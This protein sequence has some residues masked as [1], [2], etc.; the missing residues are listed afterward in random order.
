MKL[1]YNLNLQQTQKLVMTPELKQSIEILQYN[2]MELNE[3]INDALLT[4]PIL[5]KTDTS[6]VEEPKKDDL[7]SKMD[8]IDWTQ[9]SDDIQI[10]SRTRKYQEA[11]EQVNYDNF[12][13]S[14][15]TLHEHLLSQLQYTLIEEKYFR[16][17]TYI[18]QCIDPSGY[19]HMEDQYVMDHFKIDE[20]TLEEIILTVQTFDPVGVGARDLSEC[21]LIQAV[22]KHIE[23]KLVYKIITDYLE[24]VG[25]NKLNKI[26]KDLDV[27]IEEVKEAIKTIRCFEP[28][29]GRAF[30]SL[31]DI[32]YIKPDVTLR[33]I[34]GEF[35]ILVNESTAPKLYINN[36]YKQMLNEAS[37]NEKASEYISKKLGAAL[38]LIKSIEQRR[39]TIYKV[40]E[41]I[42][43]YQLDFFEK[44]P[45]YLKTLT[46]KTIADQIGVH[47]STVS[48]A[49]SGKYIQCPN[50]LYELKYFF[51]S[52]VATNRGEGVSAE[53]IKIIIKEMIEK[54]P[55]EKPLSDQNISLEF[56]KIGVKISR[57][58]VAKYRTEL[59]IPS[60]SKRKKF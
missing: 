13:A 11:A 12:V 59:G 1:S 30:A 51:Q 47:E 49:T 41:A 40:V 50:G 8:K 23:D 15:I 5:E 33:R 37:V 53:S 45:I 48:R 52:G 18:I 60:T 32:A 56:D 34:D 46:L 39:N 4:N 55:S 44:G 16:V 36:F 27:T 6:K 7:E 58:T 21:L 42:L 24:D 29:P 3:F 57:R 19:L 25:A 35:T 10:K 54:E 2:A 14:E 9:V 20:D 31:K 22:Y 26:A 38:R 28:K 17:A 43:E